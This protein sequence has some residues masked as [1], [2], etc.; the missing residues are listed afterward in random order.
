MF[1]SSKLRKAHMQYN[2]YS[3]VIPNCNVIQRGHALSHAC[4]KTHAILLMPITDA[5]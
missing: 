1:I 5:M 2:I 4:F 3:Q